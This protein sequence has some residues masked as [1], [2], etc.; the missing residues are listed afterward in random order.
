[1]SLKAF[2]SP[3]VVVLYFALFHLPLYFSFHFCII[4]QSHLSPESP[5]QT[6]STKFPL[7]P[8]RLTY[9]SLPRVYPHLLDSGSFHWPQGLQGGQRLALGTPFSRRVRGSV[10]TQ[11]GEVCASTHPRTQSSPFSPG[12]SSLTAHSVEGAARMFLETLA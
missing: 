4:H 5:L 12:S 10:G 1:M 3:C 9:I 6:W 8:A 7:L 2:P 11:L